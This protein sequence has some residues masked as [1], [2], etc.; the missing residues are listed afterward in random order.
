MRHRKCAMGLWEARDE[1]MG[2]ASI[3]L[4]TDGQ[5]KN[6]QNNVIFQLGDKVGDT[7]TSGGETQ[8]APMEPKAGIPVLLLLSKPVPPVCESHSGCDE[9]LDYFSW[10]AAITILQKHDQH[11]EIGRMPFWA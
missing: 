11:F 4:P 8:G 10:L 1:S 2:G 5:R 3:G 7:A 9:I 6:M